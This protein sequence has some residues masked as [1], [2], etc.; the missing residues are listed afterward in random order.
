MAKNNYHGTMS[1]MQRNFDKRLDTTKSEGS[2]VLYHFYIIIIQK[3]KIRIH[4][5]FQNMHMELIITML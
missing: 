2:K 3:N 1:Y 4:I 5:K